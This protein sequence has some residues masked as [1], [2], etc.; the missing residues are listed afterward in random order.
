MKIYTL[1]DEDIKKIDD[2]FKRIAEKCG[3]FVVPDLIDIA[4]II[5]GCFDHEEV[6]ND[7]NTDDIVSQ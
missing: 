2:C 7:V 5:L 4:N 1:N 3:N 6:D